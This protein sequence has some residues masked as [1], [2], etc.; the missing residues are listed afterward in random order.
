[1]RRACSDSWPVEPIP[2]LSDAPGLPMEAVEALAA[3][4]VRHLPPDQQ[5]R[6]R[7]DLLARLLGAFVDRP[8]VQMELRP[9]AASTWEAARPGPQVGESARSLRDPYRR[10]RVLLRLLDAAPD[11]ESLLDETRTTALA[12]PEPLS[13]CRICE[14]LLRFCPEER[15]ADEIASLAAD[16]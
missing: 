3:L 11:D 13:R 9:L 6:L 1:S 8:D 10:A 4:H 7:G 16:V 12:I 14:R 5:A 2:P 15:L